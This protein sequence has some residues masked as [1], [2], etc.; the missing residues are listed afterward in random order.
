MSMYVT[1]SEMKQREQPPRSDGSIYTW[2]TSE[3]LGKRSKAHLWRIGI[4]YAR[5]QCGMLYL[6]DSLRAAER[7][8]QRCKTCE[9]RRK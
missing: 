8:D 7:D 6:A 1:T 2:A 9:A 4:A 3:S 5:S